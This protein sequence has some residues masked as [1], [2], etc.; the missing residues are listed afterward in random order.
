MKEKIIKLTKYVE[1][2]KSRLGSDTPAKHASHPQAY[3]QFLEREIVAATRKIE[4]L[5]LSGA[6]EGK[7]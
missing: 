6:S 2:M 3:K 4:S 7:R 1:D 5:K